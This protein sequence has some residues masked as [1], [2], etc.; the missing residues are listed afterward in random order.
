MD[1]KL[2]AKLHSLKAGDTIKINGKIFPI[3]EK[4]T[5]PAP[6]EF[7]SHTTTFDLG[8]DYVLEFY[9]NWTFFKLVTKKGRLGFVTTKSVHSEIKEIEIL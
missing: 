8:D 6:D 9:W 1:E 7:H 5:H 4:S 2:S 3:K